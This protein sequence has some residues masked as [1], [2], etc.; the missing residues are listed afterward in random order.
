MTMVETRTYTRRNALSRMRLSM[1]REESKPLGVLAFFGAGR[2]PVAR[3]TCR[4][5]SQVDHF[6]LSCEQ[7]GVVAGVDAVVMPSC[8]KRRTLVSPGCGHSDVSS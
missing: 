4:D 7:T 2:Q 5:D 8:R 6:A 3:D 1:S